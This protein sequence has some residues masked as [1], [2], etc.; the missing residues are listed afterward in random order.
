[1]WEHRN[2]DTQTHKEAGF[3]S[4]WGGIDAC[5]HAGENSGPGLL[6]RLEKKKSCIDKNLVSEEFSTLIKSYPVNHEMECMLDHK[7]CVLLFL[8]LEPTFHSHEEVS[9]NM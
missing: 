6:G 8:R 1:M 9:G 3:L 5:G 7:P 2:T 4:G